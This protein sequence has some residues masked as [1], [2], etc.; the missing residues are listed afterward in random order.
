MGKSERDQ[1]K[2]RIWV[3]KDSS[4]NQSKRKKRAQEQP[5]QKHAI[6]PPSIPAG[7]LPGFVLIPPGSPW[8]QCHWLSSHQKARPWSECSQTMNKHCT[9]NN[10]Y[11][12][13]WTKICGPCVQKTG[14]SLTFIPLLLLCSGTTEVW[15]KWINKKR[16]GAQRRLAYMK[17]ER[18]LCSGGSGDRLNFQHHG[19]CH[20]TVTMLECGCS[21]LLSSTHTTLL[22]MPGKE[23]VCPNS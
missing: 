17:R 13:C 16:N 21:S 15:A 10:S 18:A 9:I 8:H 20:N 19:Q 7:T 4:I 22:C 3:N 14:L 1:K 23:L 5:P 2:H 11:C 12:R 6:T